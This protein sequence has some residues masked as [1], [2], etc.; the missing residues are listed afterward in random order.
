MAT[1]AL[2]AKASRRAA[3]LDMAGRLAH[4]AGGF[5]G[6]AVAFKGLSSVGERV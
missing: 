2:K 5:F 6:W 3:I 4:G 1:N